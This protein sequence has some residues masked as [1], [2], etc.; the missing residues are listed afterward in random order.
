MRML[1]ALALAALLAVALATPAHADPLSGLLIGL[2][3]FAGTT[4]GGLMLRVAAG[5][6]PSLLAR[7]LAGKPK[8]PGVRIEGTTGGEEIPQSFPIGRRAVGG[9]ERYRNS[10]GTGGTPNELF[11]MV[12][13]VSDIPGVFLRRLRV[14]DKYTALGEPGLLTSHL[15]QPML[16]F[17]HDGQD[18][19]WIKF[20][21]GTQTDADTHLV[22][23]YGDDPDQPWTV[24]HIGHGVAYAIITLRYNREV[25]QGLPEFRF[26]L[27]GIP[28][29]DPRRDSS[30]G[31]SGPHRWSD[32]ATWEPSENLALMVY[33]I[34]RGIPLPD[35]SI[36][37][38]LVPGGDLPLSN[39][40][41]GMNVCDTDIGGRAQFT[42]GL[43]VFVDREP[44]EVIEELLKA[45]L[46]QVTET[47]GVFRTRWGAPDLPVY[48]F[49]DGDIAISAPQQFDPFPGLQG[50]H[51]AIRVTHPS[52]AN[53]WEPVQTPLFTNAGWEAA[54][55]GRRLTT[56]LS[57]AACFNHGQ[58]QQIARAYIEDARRFRT[59]TLVLPPDAQRLEPLDTV[60]WTSARNG[61]VNKLFEVVQVEYLPFSLLV[62]VT[63]RER[64]PEDY[65]W[66]PDDELPPPPELE[67]TP[68]DDRVLDATDWGAEGV[69][70]SDGEGAARRPAARAW[71]PPESV[72]D[73][74]AM[75]YEA[76]IK[77]TGE[78]VAQGRATPADGQKIIRE[79]DLP[80][81]DYEIRLRPVMDRPTA[82][83]GW[84]TA[85]TPDVR[86]GEADLD[87]DIR[88][89]LIELEDWIDGGVPDLRN[90]LRD[91]RDRLRGLQSNVLDLG[92]RQY[93][94]AEQ[95]R[96]SIS[97]ELNDRSARIDETL[98]VAISD[99]AAA[100]QLVLELEARVAAAQALITQI[101]QVSASALEAF[102]LQINA[103]EAQLNS[104]AGDLSGMASAVQTIEARVTATENGLDVIASLYSELVAD[105]EAL[106]GDV[107]AQASAFQGLEV[108]VTA[109]EGELSVIATWIT[110][111]EST[112]D[113]LE[114]GVAA[115]ASAYT[116]LETRVTSNEGA[117]DI[118]A[119][120]VTGVE[121][122]LDD[123]EA[124]IAAN[125]S[126]TSSLQTQV[127][128]INGQITAMAEAITSISASTTPGNTNQANFRMQVL[129]GPSGYS[130]IGMQTRQGGAG[131]WRGASLFLDTPNNS[132][133]P[134]R[135]VASAE[136]FALT[137]GTNVRVPFSIRDGVVRIS[138][139]VVDRLS[140]LRGSLTESFFVSEAA[141]FAGNLAWGSWHNIATASFGVAGPAA[142]IPD[143][144]VIRP[145]IG[146]RL[147]VFPYASVEGVK[148]V[149]YRYRLRLFRGG[150]N[151]SNSDW[152]LHPYWQLAYEGG[153]P[154]AVTYGCVPEAI[155]FYVDTDALGVQPGDSLRV[156]AQY[157][158]ERDT[159]D[160]YALNWG[161]L[162]NS[163][164]LELQVEYF[165]R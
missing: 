82:W 108:R 147:P 124:G 144:I 105:L 102:A 62:G 48:S 76:R 31:G 114:A 64:D 26:V 113:D 140:V 126:A 118:L 57:S 51:N 53:L 88:Q 148:S 1:S 116:G 123:L 95:V 128:S 161:P 141:N 80:A 152:A 92:S 131:N 134:T 65:D 21:D 49:T 100:A 68:V 46:G 139:A 142:N 110:A 58:A 72:T 79:A 78:V 5:L 60:E 8:Q 9:H 127:T 143:Q 135:I 13:S 29:Y 14:N 106:E 54:D 59:H 74:R 10:H 91:M 16:R 81:E 132:A 115:N 96:R 145:Y 122:I 71:W 45:G 2:K 164:T 42:G 20:Y 15:G 75:R 55:A 130:R 12:I 84:K 87:G 157:I 156:Q 66:S 25:W 85:T 83:T 50:T 146:G 19:G 32:P 67:P 136:E 159:N 121:S 18:N 77:V 155:V 30:V 93:L 162:V 28:L 6:L 149:A 70:V 137:H 89:N 129:S 69:A 61:Y 39:W 35:G 120:W 90:R 109:N 3:T 22:S 101:Q 154:Y 24:N 56:L 125:A 23:A 153:V 11:T 17:R 27:D 44:A 7:A 117:L 73:A 97:V 119:S 99:S 165:Y 160:G 33:N 107:A 38:G 4:I 41:A 163:E 133:L 98:T 47:G 43:E 138:E 34:L 151:V 150:T 36:Y 94:I 37:G 103:L 158:R 104:M 63:L 86:F 40:I 52:A 111:V 112:L